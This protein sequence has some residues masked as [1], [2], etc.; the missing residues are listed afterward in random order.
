MDTYH[1]EIF[2]KALS[3]LEPLKF[4]DTTWHNDA[5][6]S[7]S[8]VTEDGED[9]IRLWIDYPD[10]ADREL[11]DTLSMFCVVAPDGSELSSDDVESA[12]KDVHRV[13]SEMFA[14]EYLDHLEANLDP[15]ERDAVRE[16]RAVPNDFTDANDFFEPSWLEA[17]KRSFWVDDH[18]PEETISIINMGM[19][20]AHREI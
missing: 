16:G 12:I 14:K 9:L 15:P 17:F 5:C 13:M 8:L 2:D 4:T 7:I 11:G 3:A 19:S 20:I 18:I 10:P 1:K 6:P